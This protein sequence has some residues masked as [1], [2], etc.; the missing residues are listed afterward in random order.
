M[1]IYLTKDL[2]QEDASEIAEVIVAESRKALNVLEISLKDRLGKYPTDVQ[3]RAQTASL[4]DMLARH[5]TPYASIAGVSRTVSITTEHLNERIEDH[6]ERRDIK[7][8]PKFS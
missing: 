2:S 1:A 3:W 7:D 5:L 8:L 4:V 6:I